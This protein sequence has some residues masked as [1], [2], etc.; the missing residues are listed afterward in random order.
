MAPEPRLR[1]LAP[2][3]TSSPD[4]RLRDVRLLCIVVAHICLVIIRV[5][6]RAALHADT[7]AFP[8]PWNFLT[9]FNASQDQCDRQGQEGMGGKSRAHSRNNGARW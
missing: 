2:P 8:F 9:V 1:G 6:A 4:V 7:I 5:F 3:L